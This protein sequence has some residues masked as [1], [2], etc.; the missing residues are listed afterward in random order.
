MYLS[1]GGTWD[2][3]AGLALAQASGARAIDRLGRAAGLSSGS[4]VIGGAEAITELM[5]ATGGL[6]FRDPAF[7]TRTVETSG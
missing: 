7:L 1:W 4:Y 2:V 5:H 6:S 3:A